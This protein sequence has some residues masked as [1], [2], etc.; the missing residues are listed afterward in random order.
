[1]AVF[2][3]GE[4][5]IA[6]LKKRDKTLGKAID[7]IGHIERS[8]NYETSNDDLF[9]A[10]IKAVVGQQ[11]STKAAAT[12]WGRMEEG[13]GMVTPEAILGISEADLQAFGISFRK[14]GYIRG[15]AEKVVTG[16][17]DIA[18]LHSKTDAEI[19]KELSSLNGIGTWTAEMLMLFAMQRPDILSYGDLAIHRGMQTLYRRKKITP[20]MF[21]GY[22][23][24]YSPHG[25]VASLYLWAI[26]GGAA[27]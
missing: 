22:R 16:C 27:Y 3:Y 15:A 21:E 11:I 17:L 23:R 2:L 12:V 7:I 8:A 20:E 5:E 24:R 25:S 26:A 9:S 18:S 10:L 6:H 13:L 1:M 14:A 4:A 19:V